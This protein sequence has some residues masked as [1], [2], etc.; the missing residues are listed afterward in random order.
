MAVV[1]RDGLLELLLEIL[2]VNISLIPRI[3]PN[4]LTGRVGN[5]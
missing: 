3:P 2:L 4:L 5:L 1:D